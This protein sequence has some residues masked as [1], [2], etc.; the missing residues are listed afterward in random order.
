M[1]RGEGPGQ[2][3]FCELPPGRSEFPSTLEPGQRGATHFPERPFGSG[4]ALFK[5]FFFSKMKKKISFGRDDC[6]SKCKYNLKLK[7][8]QCLEIVQRAAGQFGGLSSAF[9]RCALAPCRVTNTQSEV[10]ASSRTR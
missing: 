10:L 7:S 5:H 4:V 8:F 3:S 2:L 9:P 6:L 1:D